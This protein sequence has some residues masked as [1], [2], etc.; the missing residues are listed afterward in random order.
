MNMI[1]I[2]SKVRVKFIL[3]Y[4]LLFNKYIHYKRRGT[5]TSHGGMTERQLTFVNHP[6]YTSRIILVS[7]SL[8]LKMT[9]KN[10]SVSACTYLNPTNRWM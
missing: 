5:Y 9:S 3:F 6:L 10:S 7:D 2:V 8:C 1:T 4:K